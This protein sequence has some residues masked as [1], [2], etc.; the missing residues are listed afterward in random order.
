MTDS[1]LREGH[2][3]L[4]EAF[5]NGVL[6]LFDADLRYRIVGPTVLPFSQREAADMVGK[7]IDELFPAETASELESKLRAT[8]DGEARSFD[9]DYGDEIHHVETRPTSIDGRPHGVLATQAVTEHRQMAAELE[10]KTERLAEFSSMVSHDLRNPLN[11]AQGRLAMYRQTGDE[12]HLDDVDAALDRIHELTTSLLAL[13]RHGTPTDILEPVTLESVAEDAWTMVETKSGTLETEPGTVRG[14]EG[15]L[16]GLF[17]NLFR[18][19]V[20]HGGP[21]VTVRVGPL[22]GGFYVEDTGTGIPPEEHEQVFE[23]GFSTGYSGSGVGLAIV[24]RIA[25]AHGFGTSVGES[26]EG[27]ARF[28]F[29]LTSESGGQE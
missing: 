6:V 29:A 3:T 14:D 10:R 28:E 2:Q 15:Q 18:N 23:H 11:V 16:R 17:E 27:G 5:P 8:L 21:A 9:M 22:D 12:A 26:A 19:A 4:V 1:S 20:G 13:A 25:D 7:T 24:R